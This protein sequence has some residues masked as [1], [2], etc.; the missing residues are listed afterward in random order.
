MTSPIQSLP[1]LNRRSLVRGLGAGAIATSAI[2][3]IPA[4]AG[5]ATGEDPVVAALA[6]LARVRERVSIIDKMYSGAVEALSS[7]CMGRLH[8]IIDGHNYFEHESI[9]SHF[10]GSEIPDEN[11]D[12]AIALLNSFRQRTLTQAEQAELEAMRKAAHA[13]LDGVIAAR[14]ETRAR[15]G[16][17]ELETKVEEARTAEGDAEAEVFK[18]VPARP[19]GALMLLRSI[20]DFIDEYGVIN[21]YIN[22]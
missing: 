11:A 19:A 16:V 9:D 7:D 4:V 10:D 1:L 6:E 13:E 3:S 5:A 22:N 20:A 12:N 2:A 14:T 15:S 21:Q 18:T 17:D 8:V